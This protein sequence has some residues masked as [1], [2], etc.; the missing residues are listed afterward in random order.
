MP[1]RILVVD[2]E[3]VILALV[4]DLLEMSGYEVVRASD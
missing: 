3:P 1:E 2:D 4:G